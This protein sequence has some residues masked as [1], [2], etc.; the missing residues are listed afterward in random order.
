MTVTACSGNWPMC[1]R[2]TVARVDPKPAYGNI[3]VEDWLSA[4]RVGVRLRCDGT[5]DGTQRGRARTR[6]NMRRQLPTA[7]RAVVFAGDTA[8]PRRNAAGTRVWACRLRVALSARTPMARALRH[9]TN[10]VARNCDGACADGDARI[11]TQ[12]VERYEHAGSRHKQCPAVGAA[13]DSPHV[14]APRPAP[15]GTRTADY[16]ANRGL[17]CCDSE[18]ERASYAPDSNRRGPIEARAVTIRRRVGGEAG[19]ATLEFINRLGQ[20]DLTTAEGFVA[21]NMGVPTAR[22]SLAEAATVTE[23]VCCK[24]VGVF[25]TVVPAFPLLNAVGH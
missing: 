8:C 7:R 10:A 2:R 6:D 19:G 15:C 16:Q 20:D 21:R 25:P 14:T 12:R 17:G 3:G 24:S 1:G 23:C 11:L 5:N 13:I 22:A 4:G 9:E 18:R